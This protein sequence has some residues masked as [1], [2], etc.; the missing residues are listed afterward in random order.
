MGLHRF[1]PWS[2]SPGVSPLLSHSMFHKPR[3]SLWSTAPLIWTNI[4]QSTL[5][6]G[7]PL[8]CAMQRTTLD[9]AYL[10]LTARHMRGCKSRRLISTPP[11]LCLLAQARRARFSQFVSTNCAFQSHGRVPT[12]DSPTSHSLPASSQPTLVSVLIR[13]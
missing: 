9:H 4:H 7:Q 13:T 12:S 6:W 2:G 8:T 5:T 1:S 11:A 3:H 10:L